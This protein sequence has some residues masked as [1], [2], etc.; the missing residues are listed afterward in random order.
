MSATVTTAPRRGSIGFRLSI[1][2]G[3][4]LALIVTLGVI[5]TN[6]VN[7]ISASLATINDVNSV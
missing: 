5:A 6:R 3:L 2:F 1:G 4:V 7:A